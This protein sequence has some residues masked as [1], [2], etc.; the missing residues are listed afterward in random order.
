MKD[1]EEEKDDDNYPKFPEYGDTF[2]GEAEEGDEG[3]SGGE[4]E[5][6]AYDDE[7]FCSSKSKKFLHM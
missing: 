2:M 1:N 6:E 4:A 7:R 3:G 5:G